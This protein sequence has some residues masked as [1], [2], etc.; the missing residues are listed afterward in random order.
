[1]KPEKKPQKMQC[2]QCGAPMENRRECGYCGMKYYSGPDVPPSM[3][4]GQAETSDGWSDVFYG[5]SSSCTMT[6]VNYLASGPGMTVTYV[7]QASRGDCYG[8]A[9]TVSVR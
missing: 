8:V 5:T 7:P 6:T 1:M 9:P 4:R 2:E 3:F